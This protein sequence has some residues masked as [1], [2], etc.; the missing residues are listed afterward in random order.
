MQ[1]LDELCRREATSPKA[2][3]PLR[4][5]PGENPASPYPEDGEHWAGVYHELVTF[6]EGLIQQVQ[7]AWEDVSPEARAEIERDVSVLQVELE[8]LKLHLL[9]WEERRA[10]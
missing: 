3:V 7:A 10:T 6:K 4:L 8:R 9:F 2:D 5:L 1:S